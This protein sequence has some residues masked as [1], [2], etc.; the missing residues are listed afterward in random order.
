MNHPDISV[1]YHNIS[2]RFYWIGR[3][4]EAL[5]NGSQLYEISTCTL[6]LEHGPIKPI[7]YYLEL[8]K[9]RMLL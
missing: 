7:Q 2:I 1:I 4:N 8:A 6:S 9:H 3:L 5:E